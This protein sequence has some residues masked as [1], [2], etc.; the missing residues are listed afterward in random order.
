MKHFHRFTIT[1]QQLPNLGMAFVCG[2]RRERSLVGN[3]RDFR[4]S[5]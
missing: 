3:F 1:A 5:P 2:A 4:G